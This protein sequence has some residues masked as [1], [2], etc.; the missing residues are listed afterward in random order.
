MYLLWTCLV[1]VVGQCGSGHAAGRLA[2]SADPSSHDDDG[3]NFSRRGHVGWEPLQRRD[4]AV[5]SSVTV[6]LLELNQGN[7]WLF[8]D[9][10][11]ITG[12]AAGSSS[13]PN[14]RF[15][16]SLLNVAGVMNFTSV[17]AYL[18]IPQLKS[19]LES[20]TSTVGVMN[21]KNRYVSVELRPLAAFS[22]EL[23]SGD[24]ELDINGPVQVS[25]PVSD[26]LGQHI[27]KS[28]PAWFLNMTTGAWKKK[29][30]GQVVLMEGK[31]VWTF[32]APHLGYWIAAS[33][34]SSREFFQLSVFIDFI[35]HHTFFLMV[36][37]GGMLLTI[38]CLL[39]GL[40][41]FCRREVSEEN[42]LKLTVMRRKDQS[43]STSC[44]EASPGHVYPQQE[45][46]MPQTERQEDKNNAAFISGNDDSVIR[47][48]AAVA[49]TVDCDDVELEMDLCDPMVFF[50]EQ[51]K[52]PESL[53][54]SLF[55][56]NQQVAN[57][58]A[59][60][61]LHVEERTQRRKSATLPRAG[62]SHSAAAEPDT[63]SL[64]KSPSVVQNQTEE[65]EGRLDDEEANPRSPFPESASVPGTLS[66]IGQ[67]RNSGETAAGF[68]KTQSPQPPRA[69]FV[70]LEG[71][72]A[73]EIHH[74][75]AE[76]HRRR[77][78]VESRDTSL[79]SGV[80]MSEL[81]PGPVRRA[82]TLDR[83]ATFVKRTSQQ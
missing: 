40:L 48:P 28:V 41:N 15:P 51:V 32:T 2:A 12:K 55:F 54:E 17:K 62:A 47:N 29:G 61:F 68:S 58:P 75:T 9:Y 38:V 46:S 27:S 39:L 37:L 20:F 43:T 57:L 26:G 1:L 83:R 10:V 77:R 81:N 34:S 72:P 18:T 21:S 71:K 78:P 7:M 36:I 16:K 31:R 42:A 3:D 11:V 19:E 25:L 50:S 5:F 45:Q 30:L 23:F 73:A 74:A 53:V 35:S 49:V 63:N 22:V 79:D 24:I 64:P 76:Q 44:D 82:G 66:K 4:K 65:A 8:E 67:N 60:A 33:A 59:T 52:T 14:I 70:S 13:L 69:W 80:D 6:S 56:C